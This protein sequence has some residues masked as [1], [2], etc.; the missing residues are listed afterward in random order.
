MKQINLKQNQ[1]ATKASFKN[2]K[3]VSHLTQE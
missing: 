1:K 3:V 2:K